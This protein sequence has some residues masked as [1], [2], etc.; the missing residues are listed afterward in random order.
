ML[1]FFTKS[2][3]FRGEKNLGRTVGGQ[4]MV[5]ACEIIAQGLAAVLSDEDGARIADPGHDFKGIGR[6]DLQMLRCDLIGCVNGILHRLCHQD[7][8]VIAPGISVMMS[9]LERTSTNPSDL[10]GYF[11]RQLHAGGDQ[12]W[13]MP[14]RRALPG[15]ARS[16]ATYLGLAVSSA[17]TRISLG[18]AMESMLTNGRRLLFWPEPH[19][20]C[21]G[22]RSYRLW[23]WTLCQRPVLRWPG[24]H[25]PCRPHRHLP[26]WPPPE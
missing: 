12:G 8:T 9:L 16:A 23:G 18:P 10:L 24:R 1:D 17:S 22:P 11:L 4:H 14:S 15:T 3:T 2:S 19:R 25:L 26:R 7:V 6:H 20:C 5:G 13:R 21:L